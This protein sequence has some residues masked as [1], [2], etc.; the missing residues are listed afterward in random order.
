MSARFTFCIPNLN[1]IEFLDACMQSVLAQDCD[2]WC[3]VFVDGFSTDGC[4]DY[5]QRFADDSR[6]RLLRGLKQG[7]YADW[8]YCLEQVESEYF[9][10]LPSDDT[11]FPSLVS[12]TIAALDGF[13]DILACHFQY[14]F[15][16]RAGETTHEP[17]DVMRMNS[18]L[19]LEPNQSAHIRSGLCEFMMHFAYRSVYRTMTSLVMRRS[20]IDRLGGFSQDYGSIG[21]LDWAMRLCLITDVLFIPEWLATW[22]LYEGQATQLN[23]VVEQSERIL[24]VVVK[25][26]EAV[27]KSPMYSGRL[28]EWD[29]R[30]TLSQVEG[31]YYSTLTRSILKGDI[32]VLIH[33]GLNLEYISY[34]LRKLVYVISFR[35]LFGYCSND[36][37]ADRLIRRHQLNWPPMI[38]SGQP[39]SRSA[40]LS[41]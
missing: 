18:P 40:A 13:P 29:K 3:C 17:D 14:S 5:M 11:C 37:F 10:F 9:Y 24:A 19:Y 6:F 7:M 36:E 1:K 4:W 16:N 27:A 28:T 34:L 20:V 8:N 38:V 15:I 32:R 41:S 22:R 21:D 25:N 39:Q 35:S 30:T 31:A 23:Q 33:R 26:L 12:K 2:D